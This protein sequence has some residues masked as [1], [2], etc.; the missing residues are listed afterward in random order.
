[1]NAVVA[2]L[3][4]GLLSGIGAA[5]VLFQ[6]DFQS[7]D[8]ERDSDFSIGGIPSGNWTA[9][10][11]P[12]FSRGNEIFNTGNFGGTRLWVSD[13]HGASITS[14]GIEGLVSNTDYTFSTF[15]CVETSDGNRQLNASYDL[16]IGQ[17]V[18]SAVSVIGG[19]AAVL[20]HGDSY[21]TDDSK[22]EHFFSETFTTGTLSAGD[23]LFIVITIIDVPAGKT[24]GFIGVDDVRVAEVQPIE[25]VAYETSLTEGD[26]AGLTYD[27]YVTGNPTETVQVTATASD[28]LLVNDQ[29]EMTLVFTPPVDPATSQTVTVTAVNDATVE[30]IHSG[31]VTHTPSSNLS[32]YDTLELPSLN[33]TIVDDD[34]LT[35]PV[36]YI[37]DVFVGGQE[38][39]EGTSNYRIPGMT[40]AADGSILAFAEGRRNGSDP[41]AAGYPID[42]VMKR[43]T[44]NG[45][46]WSDLVVM[47]TDVNFDYSDPRPITDWQTGRINF[48][49]MQWPDDCG[50]TCV[51]VGL[52]DNSSVVFLQTSDD[53]GQTWA[54]PINI[55]SQVKDPAWKALNCGPGHGIQLQWQTDSARNGRLV[56]PGHYNSSNGIAIYSD[57]NGS[58]WQ[59]GSP[60]TGSSLNESEVVELTN[61]D[62]L[63]DAR[64]SDYRKHALSQDGGETWTYLGLGDIHITAVDCSIAR[65]SAARQGDDRDRLIFSGPLGN[66][67]GSGSGRYNMAVWTSYDE[68]DSF[69]NP[70]Q[71]DEG[72]GA[73]SVLQRLADGT[74]G[75]FYEE[76]GNTLIR[77]V[78]CSMETLEN[79]P[80]HNTLS[81][82]D[83]FG[84]FVDNT[85]GGVGW[86]SVWTGDA[87]FT[88]SDA[89][90][91]G[92][93]SIPFT[94]FPFTPQSGRVDASATG[95]DIQRSLATPLDMST[96]G[97][98]YM[99]LLVSRLLDTSENDDAQESLT[100]QLRDD[101]G[102]AHIAF[103][104]DSNEA[105]FVEEPGNTIATAADAFA[106]DKNYFLIAKIIK[107]DGFDQIYLRA[108]ES[109]T[110]TVPSN[111]SEISWTLVGSTNTDSSAVLDHISMVG[112]AQATWSVDEVRIGTTYLS[113]T[114]FG[115]SLCGQEG[116]VYLSGD[117]NKDCYVNFWDLAMLAKDWL[118]C[119][120]PQNPVECN[121]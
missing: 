9:D 72:W 32:E 34:L 36:N 76:T 84:N 1:M 81:Q 73:Y 11:D 35:M 40:V 105:F 112:G 87:D 58:T 103:G 115:D 94:G 23:K 63:W 92:G 33:I 69:T 107:T 13:D 89:P 100:V 17:N 102:T 16:L 30:G 38:G 49:Y 14:M 106:L 12:A 116:T 79:G 2:F 18:G 22:E 97:A 68:G 47:H 43:S 77:F 51:P 56:A 93:A 60:I 74:I 111:E 101:A 59:S 96:E 67:V 8:V 53:H 42:M 108:V 4:L 52:G 27:I 91:F 54:G 99:S 45:L 46:T 119:T 109:G 21:I 98:I 70:V 86:T 80:H 78:N 110:E 20:L 117:L 29:A 41:G 10:Y 90:A 64:W 88:R 6:D 113:V 66:P 37:S 62:L 57:D 15:M 118:M 28:Q 104:I 85:R 82:Y 121:Q 50:Q 39:P 71:I 120:D 5:A 114:G 65:Y 44:D 19:P 31:L 7:Y 26:P 3:F 25:I 48:L 83:G 24:G 61:G 95:M 75:V 55:N